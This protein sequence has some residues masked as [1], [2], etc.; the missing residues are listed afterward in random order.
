[1]G[2]ELGLLEFN[3]SRGQGYEIFCVELICAFGALTGLLSMSG[4][5]SKNARTRVTISQK[6]YEEMVESRLRYA[7]LKQII[8]EDIFSP[9]PTRKSKEVIDA[10]RKTKRY[11]DA[12]LKSLAKGLRRSSHFAS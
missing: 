4:I 5:L 2:E 11:S 3:L 7:Y 6:E 1:M 12:F 10:F 9:P 8:E